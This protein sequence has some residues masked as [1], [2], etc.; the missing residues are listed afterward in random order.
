M[1]HS[2]DVDVVKQ[3]YMVYRLSMIVYMNTSGH[4]GVGVGVVV[5]VIP[6]HKAPILRPS[7]SQVNLE[8][9]GISSLSTGRMSESAHRHLYSQQFQDPTLLAAQ[10]IAGNTD[11]V[12][13]VQGWNTLDQGC[14]QTKRSQL[15]LHGMGE[16]IARRRLRVRG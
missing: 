7:G 11:G 1:G 10:L 5:T 2:P 16:R 13:V 3:Q 15:R 12:S 8:F 4:L 6:L 9:L 14:G